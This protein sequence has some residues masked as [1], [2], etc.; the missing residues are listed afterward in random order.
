MGPCSSTRKLIESD[1]TNSFHQILL[2]V[3][4]VGSHAVASVV[5][6]EMNVRKKSHA[7]HLNPQKSLPL[8]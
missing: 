1:L 2:E 5:F 3:T 8:I 6:S 7:H 4:G